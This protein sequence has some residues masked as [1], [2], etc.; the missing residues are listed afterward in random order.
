MRL[1]GE[2]Q[3]CQWDVSLQT[4]NC[5]E[6]DQAILSQMVSKAIE[7]FFQEIVAQTLNL[8][9]ARF[10]TLKPTDMRV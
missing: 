10:F 1:S 2:Q 8:A 5:Y 3:A 6:S 7:P 4:I 9:P